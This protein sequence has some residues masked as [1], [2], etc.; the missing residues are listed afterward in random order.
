[1]RATGLDWHFHRQ[2]SIA[3]SGA[4]APQ[5]L[6]TAFGLPESPPAM[7]MSQSSPHLKF[8]A[9]ACQSRSNNES[10]V[11]VATY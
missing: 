10:R 3:V 4:A 11:E 9:N 8:A 6:G 1:M 2:F 5:S 7:A